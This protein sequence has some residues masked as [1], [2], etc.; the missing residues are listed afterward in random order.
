GRHVR[1]CPVEGE[2]ADPDCE[3]SM[4]GGVLFAADEPLVRTD[5][6]QLLGSHNVENAMAAAAAA[7]AS[8]VRRDAVAEGLRSFTGVRHRLER[9]REL[10]GVLYVNDS[11]ATNAASARARIRP[12]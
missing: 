12:F 1:F 2:S 3:L 5:E 11:K 8:G 7:L 6:L 9:V 4:G 10:G